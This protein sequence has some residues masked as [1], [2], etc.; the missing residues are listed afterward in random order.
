MRPAIDFSIGQ[1]GRSSSMHSLANRGMI[2]DI[3]SIPMMQPVDTGEVVDPI[4]TQKSQKVPDLSLIKEEP[5]DM[6]NQEGSPRTSR[7]KRNQWPDKLTGIK[8]DTISEDDKENNVSKQEKEKNESKDSNEQQEQ[9][10]ERKPNKEERTRETELLVQS[11]DEELLA[12]GLY[13]HRYPDTPT[14]L[15]EQWKELR[16]H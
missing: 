2:G 8:M 15:L 9:K 11:C 12:Q 4:L 16:A 7:A 10:S 3:R 5:E 14:D 13:D 1:M 6:Q